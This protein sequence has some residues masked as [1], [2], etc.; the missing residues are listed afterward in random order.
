[1]KYE[2]VE[3]HNVC[4]VIATPDDVGFRIC[5][6]PAEV[7][8]QVNQ[9]AQ[10]NSYHGTGCEIR[11]MLADDG[12]ARVV[13]QVLGDNC[14]PPIA[15][16]YHGCFSGQAV[17]V[18]HEPTEINITQP[19]HS[20]VMQQIARDQKLPFDPRLVRIT[21]PHIHPVRILAIEGDLTCPAADA[22]PAKTMLCYGS[23]I[24]H[25][26]HAIGPH[27]TYAA[28]T[29]SRLGCDLV[30]LGFGGSAH[31][32]PAMARHIAARDDW[33]FAT[34]EMGINV[35]AWPTEKFRAAVDHFVTTIVEAH[36]DKFVFC[37]DLFTNN[38]DYDPQPDLAVGFREVVDE[39]AGKFASPRVIHLDGRD[40]LQH[41]GG[42][43]VDLV[44][45]N[46]HG[47]QEMGA[48]LAAA[49][50]KAMG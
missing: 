45:P 30:N 22:T 26:A 29:A 47:M 16:V 2:N 31:M 23:S 43:Q 46:D 5:R 3:L 21:L 8:E 4:E 10:N 18:G 19:A 42:L 49:I 14:V 13:L 41:P 17:L 11:G 50:T 7:R 9:G 34:L 39:I 27:S 20:A 32:D 35:R 38:N 25:G 24:T 33:D 37:I 12:K 48:N 6:L 15:T 28:Q 1:V 40:L 44:H 36:P